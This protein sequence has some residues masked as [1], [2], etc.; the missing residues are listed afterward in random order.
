MTSQELS[1]N[2]PKCWILTQNSSVNVYGPASYA[3]RFAAICKHV[4][5]I[6]APNDKC[7][8]MCKYARRKSVLHQLRPPAVA[9]YEV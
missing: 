1:K 6:C 8:E 2:S 4:I 3:H 9:L 5:A 7:S